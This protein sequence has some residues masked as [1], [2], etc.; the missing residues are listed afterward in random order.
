MFLGGGRRAGRLSR[1]R[2]GQMC[3]MVISTSE[4]LLLFR[5]HRHQHL[6]MVKSSLDPCTRADRILN[7]HHSWA[8]ALLLLVPLTLFTGCTSARPP[9]AINDVKPDVVPSGSAALNWNLPGMRLR[10]LNPGAKHL[11][12]IVTRSTFNRLFPPT[13]WFQEGSVVGM[14]NRET[15]MTFLVVSEH[16]FDTWSDELSS[17]AERLCHEKAHRA[18]DLYDGDQWSELRDTS[19]SGLDLDTHHFGDEAEVMVSHQGAFLTSLL[20]VSP[21]KLVDDDLQKW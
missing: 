15:K 14:Y 3:R 7:M 6:V 2:L 8:V 17:L 9:L 12:A 4:Q 1:S 18:D 11:D 21:V 10:I 13:V 19:G 16:A 20:P 5:R